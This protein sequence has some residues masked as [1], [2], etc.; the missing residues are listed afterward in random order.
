MQQSKTLFFAII[1]VAIV[2]LVGLFVTRFFLAEPLNL[3]T[4]SPEILIEVVVAP[5][6]KPWVDKAAQDFNQANSKT[7]VKV[8]AT[9]QL[10]PESQFQISP[11]ATPPAAWLAEASFV[12]DMARN[13]G[14]QFDEAQSV[15]S[16]GLAWGVYKD[17]LDQFEQEYGS[18]T[19]QNLHTK[20]TDDMLKVVI[21]S[22]QNSAEGMAPLISATAAQ[23]N[24]QTLSGSDVSAANVWLT[25]TLGNRN[26]EIRA[27]PAEDFITKGRSAGDAGIL[28]VA[29]WHRA[30]LDKKADVF[31]IMPVEP[32]VTLDFPFAI[33]TGSQSTPDTQEA[34]RAF[35]D[36][37]LQDAQQN[38][39]AS[40]FFEPANAA[41]SGVQADGNAGQRL[42]DWA[43]RE[44]R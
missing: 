41:Q 36:F 25:E 37:L 29:S 21:A 32:Q 22:P 35:R 11:Q 12:V 26:A 33:W 24:K 1:G 34:A 42:L 3:P 44:L 30:G 13:D 2:I 43:N 20:A 23:Q 16:S 15:A 10:I 19:W 28:T 8:I 4:D 18:L 31:S 39:L 5:S 27:T 9:D 14:L 17:K 6:V 38:G 40:F 7:Q